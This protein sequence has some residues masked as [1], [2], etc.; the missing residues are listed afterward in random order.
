MEKHCYTCKHYDVGPAREPCVGCIGTPDRV[1]WEAKTETVEVNDKDELISR[2]YVKAI[3]LR[4]CGDS[5][6]SDQYIEDIIRLLAEA[7]SK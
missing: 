6:Y 2:A 7:L 4:G 5:D 3:E 1:N